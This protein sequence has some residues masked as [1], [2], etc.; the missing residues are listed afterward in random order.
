MSIKWRRQLLVIY[1][2]AVVARISHV[3]IIIMVQRLAHVIKSYFVHAFAFPVALGSTFAFERS[4]PSFVNH[5]WAFLLR[6]AYA[7]ACPARGV[8]FA[9]SWAFSFRRALRGNV[10]EL[11]ACEALAIRISFR[12][13][14]SGV[15]LH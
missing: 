1:V 6:V 2:I 14:F 9:F 15:A 7:S 10:S 8:S 5:A 13:A 4:F 3:R 12:V 11:S